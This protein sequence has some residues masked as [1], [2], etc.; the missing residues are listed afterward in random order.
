MIIL[1]SIFNKIVMLECIYRIY[2]IKTCHLL[3]K[4]E[5]NLNSIKSILSHISTSSNNL[6]IIDYIEKQNYDI[7]Y[8]IVKSFYFNY[9][10]H[11]IKDQKFNKSILH[12]QITELSHEYRF[13]KRIN[14]SITLYGIIV[15]SYQ[16]GLKY[17]FFEEN[18]EVVG[19]RLIDKDVKMTIF[20]FRY[21]AKKLEMF[22]TTGPNILLHEHERITLFTMTSLISFPIIY[23]VYEGR[24][25]IMKRP[26]NL[27]T[28]NNDF[29]IELQ[30][31]VLSKGF[32]IDIVRRQNTFV[33]S[34]NQ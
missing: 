13:K 12:Q 20:Q 19:I 31:Y 7:I 9:N 26:K 29:L 10:I 2:N 6:R 1:H 4:I 16:N 25:E 28:E 3:D 11:K 22:L 27:Q 18:N 30:K 34:I 23:I 24:D 21:F 14:C 17:R 32:V 5:Q 15:S 33:M 8:N